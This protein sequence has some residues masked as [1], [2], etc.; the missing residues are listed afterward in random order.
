MGD[1]MSEWNDLVQWL[2][3]DVRKARGFWYS[4]PLY[5]LRDL[6]EEQLFWVP[7]E[8][9]LCLLWHAGHIAHR[10]RVHFHNIIQGLEGPAVPPTY[11]VF[12]TEW[13]SPDQVRE[14]VGSVE[15]VTRWIGEV[16]DQSTRFIASLTDAAFHQV[17]AGAD[18]EGLTVGHWLLITVGH[19]AI[20]IGKM[21]M[22]RAMLQKRRD[23]PC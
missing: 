3:G 5:E 20:H 14:A 23:N 11:E 6:T 17:A 8:G 2:Y 21:Q 12:G 19:G 4:H 13:V 16:R 1:R 10:E 9:S 22:L 15:D 7:D 18:V